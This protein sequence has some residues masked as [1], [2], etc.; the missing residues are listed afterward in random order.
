MLRIVN[1]TDTALSIDCYELPSN[2]SLDIDIPYTKNLKMMEKYN[3]IAVVELQEIPVKTME[4]PSQ[5]KS[6]NTVDEGKEKPKPKYN[7]SKKK[8]EK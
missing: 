5:Q 7:R 3:M 6:E 1:K 2:G 4:I 8:N